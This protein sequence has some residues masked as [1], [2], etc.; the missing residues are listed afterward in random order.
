MTTRAEAIAL[1]AARL[2]G[3][4]VPEPE[5]DA[6]LLYRWA[7]GMEGA[8]LQGALQDPARAAELAKFDRAIE[9]REHRKPVSQIVGFREF[10]GQRFSVSPA[11]LDP[12]PD[13]EALIEAVLN[14]KSARVLDLGTGSGCL[15]LTLL[16][17]W[18]NATGVG[19][20]CSAAALEVAGRNAEALDLRARATFLQSDWFEAV[21]GE[22]D[23]IVANPPYL[24][25][26]E[27]LDAP[28][29]LAHEPEG[30]LSPG[31]DGLDAYRQILAGVG[32]HLTANGRIALEIGANQAADV[33]A[34]AGKA[35]LDMIR[36]L[37]DLNGRDRVILAENKGKNRR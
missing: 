26:Q 29:E 27:L 1:A 35:S 7:A 34:L 24:S 14:A 6:R 25:A 4:G 8:S 15:L 19:V 37:Q 11:V 5:R 2:A 31:G 3:A 32:R 13:S 10:W 30:A 28:P 36:I 23:L 9:A 12:R 33:A 16:A 17:E 22:F 18:P 20:D 21:E